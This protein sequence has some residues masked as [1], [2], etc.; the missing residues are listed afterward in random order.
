M[1]SHFVPKMYL[2][3]WQTIYN[4]REKQICVYR[5]G[6]KPEFK[7]LKRQVGWREDYYTSE[8]EE[9]L[10]QKIESKSEPILQKVI[11]EIT[12]TSAEKIQLSRFMYVLW[13]RVPY[14]REGLFRQ[15]REVTLPITRREM[16]ITH[17]SL[18]H[19]NLPEEAF[20]TKK[21]ETPEHEKEIHSQLIMRLRYKQP[22]IFATMHW[23]VYKVAHG[24]EFVTSDNP[25]FYDRRLSLGNPKSYF[26]FPISKKL[27]LKGT[28]TRIP[29]QYYEQI[30]ADQT[31][32]FNREI[33][34]NC[35]KEVYAS[36]NDPG[37]AR[38]VDKY[39]GDAASIKHEIN[40]EYLSQF[41]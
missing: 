25:F 9:L 1:R 22:L 40:A 2:K 37:I 19:L 11:E 29:G 39:A 28:R 8:T 17:E 7:S 36:V 30:G 10:D 31:D 5:K 3:S 35:D 12:L 15:I 41:I 33:I 4:N 14:H 20:D 34:K 18:K 27:L 13:I 23:R 6:G 16:E 26:I 24:K 38:I 32:E 21:L